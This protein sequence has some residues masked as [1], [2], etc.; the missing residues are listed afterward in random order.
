MNHAL[1]IVEL[2][3]S[4]YHLDAT[5]DINWPDAPK[6]EIEE[7]PP[8]GKRSIGAARQVTSAS[9]GTSLRM[10]ALR[11]RIRC[12]RGI[13]GSGDAGKSHPESAAMT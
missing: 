1:N 13:T 8:T 10:A 11:R 7:V 2:D 6:Y 5:W 12:R 9:W 3:G 4:Y